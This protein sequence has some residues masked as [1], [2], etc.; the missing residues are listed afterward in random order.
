M[1]T[2]NSSRNRRALTWLFI[3]LGAL[4]IAPVIYFFIDRLRTSPAERAERQHRQ[5]VQAL[6]S[7]PGGSVPALVDWVQQRMNDPESFQHVETRYIDR[8]GEILV[9]M[10]YRGRNAFGGTVTEKVSA[11]LSNSGRLSDVMKVD[12]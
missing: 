6:F 4:L 11:R 3:G 5:E 1:K 12:P 9:F 2:E 7:G 10:T 8:G